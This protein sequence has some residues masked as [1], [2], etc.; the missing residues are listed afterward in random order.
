MFEGGVA[1]AAPP[2]NPD[3]EALGTLVHYQRGAEIYAGPDARFCYRL[4]SG[5]ARKFALFP[6]GRR[7]IVDFLFA[8]DYFNMR[9]KHRQSFTAEA[10][11]APTIV[12]RFP[13]HPLERLAEGNPPVASYLL[14]RAYDSMAR[15]DS[16][17]VL[18]GR[19]TAVEKVGSF[20]VAMA[21]RM[22]NAGDLVMLPMPRSDVADYLAVSVETV[23]RAFTALCRLGAITL[24]DVRG[25]RI[26][27]RLKLINP[28]GR[29]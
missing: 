18:L 10:V 26:L 28:R 12:M 13:F 25:I 23:S 14:Q 1:G 8:G 5:A 29:N 19:V 20:I 22:A 15:S 24:V 2:R 27:S 7:Q 21:E 3:V 6:D 16:R 9:Q 4:E 11:V 17:T